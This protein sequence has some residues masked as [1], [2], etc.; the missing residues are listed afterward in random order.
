MI[1]VSKTNLPAFIMIQSCVRI[2]R[3]NV[4]KESCCFQYF[5]MITCSRLNLMRSNPRALGQSTEFAIGLGTSH[6]C[7]LCQSSSVMSL[8]VLSW[9]TFWLSCMLLS[10][11]R[12]IFQCKG[13]NGAAFVP[14]ICSQID[15][16]FDWFGA[17]SEKLTFKSEVCRISTASRNRQDCQAQIAG[18]CWCQG[19]A[20]YKA[21]PDNSIEMVMIY[22]WENRSSQP[23]KLIQS[24]FSHLAVEHC[25][26]PK[27]L[28][29]LSLLAKLH[30]PVLWFGC[31]NSNW[32]YSSRV[33]ID[34]PHGAG[35]NTFDSDIDHVT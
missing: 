3:H 9:P 20:F 13:S 2:Q 16:D 30:P 18:M 21:R 7:Q 19:F 31:P 17:Y 23:T 6:F 15:M 5:L 25:G 11:P 35:N 24:E 10:I 29:C 8:H 1:C 22:L 12:A 32:S 34:L 4:A 27:G 26:T 14:R 28:W 33:N